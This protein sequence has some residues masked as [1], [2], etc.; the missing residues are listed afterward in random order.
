MVGLIHYAILYFQDVEGVIAFFT[1]KDIPGKNDFCGPLFGLVESE[2][3]KK[4]V[5]IIFLDKFIKVI[6]Y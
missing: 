3:V 2:E 4:I 6:F 1:S 5:F